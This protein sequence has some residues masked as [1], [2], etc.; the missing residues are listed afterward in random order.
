MIIH[1]RVYI[2]TKRE[3]IKIETKY[4]NKSSWR[5]HRKTNK[6]VKKYD[7]KIFESEF[8]CKR[9][10]DFIRIACLRF[11]HYKHFIAIPRLPQHRVTVFEMERDYILTRSSKLEGSPDSILATWMTSSPSSA[12]SSWINFSILVKRLVGS[13][14]FPLV[15]YLINK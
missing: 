4:A 10:W 9:V 1:Q 11:H 6:E 8:A 14:C 13:A 3:R 7:R 12:S 5:T 2:R 15:Y